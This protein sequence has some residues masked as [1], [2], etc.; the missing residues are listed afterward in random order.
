MALECFTGKSAPSTLLFNLSTGAEPNDINPCQHY[1]F[2]YQI[3]IEKSANNHLA[4]VKA[5]A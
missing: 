4:P 3:I 2:N 5:K 1:H